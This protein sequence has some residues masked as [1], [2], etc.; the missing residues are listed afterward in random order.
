MSLVEG[1]DYYMENGLFVLKAEYLLR[2]G[3]CCGNGC[4]HCPY[5]KEDAP[6]ARAAEGKE[7][8]LE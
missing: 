5:P 4:R 2:R 8:V 1:R 3:Y 7:A 6:A